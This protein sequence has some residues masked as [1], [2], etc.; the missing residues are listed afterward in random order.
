VLVTFDPIDLVP[1]AND[2]AALSI[3]SINS[4]LNPIVNPSTSSKVLELDLITAENSFV[5]NRWEFES[6]RSIPL[7][8][9]ISMANCFIGSAWIS[10]ALVVLN[11]VAVSLNSSPL[12][13]ACVVKAGPLQSRPFHLMRCLQRHPRA[14]ALLSWALVLA[15]HS[16]SLSLL[17]VLPFA[18]VRWDQNRSQKAVVVVLTTFVGD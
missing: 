10:T 14:A 6:T 2:R 9:P 16:C 11:K 4:L 7:T 13:F 5:N 17:S 15:A 3:S 12:L 8:I 18:S 1:G